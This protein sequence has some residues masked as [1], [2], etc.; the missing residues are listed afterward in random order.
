V[1]EN[2]AA[3]WA[4]RAFRLSVPKRAKFA[5]LTAMLGPTAGLTC[6]DI[7]ADN[8]VISLLLRRR[9]G[10]WTSADLDPHAVAAIQSLVGGEVYTL[11]GGRTPFPDAHFD[12]V[13]IV[14]FLEH[15][16]DDAGFLQEVGR[17]LKPGG[18][19]V[20]NV[21]HARGGP[22]RRLRLALGQT[23]ARHGHLRPGY[24][25]ADLERLTAG[26][27]TGLETR[28]YSRFFAELID[29]LLVFAVSR[30]GGGQSA[31]Q[32]GLVLSGADLARRGGLLR[33]YALIFPFVWLFA[34]LDRLLPWSAGYLLIGRAQRGA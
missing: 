12:R 8:G 32:K 16:P 1:S 23:D 17:I 25:R 10:A 34:Q 9:G 30:G 26:I 29:A 14:D 15:I 18:W 2:T 13:V 7:G 27:F 21:P 19:L 3:A 5:A 24:T 11:D 28:T 4:L 31:S 33:V 6:L 20:V 22:I